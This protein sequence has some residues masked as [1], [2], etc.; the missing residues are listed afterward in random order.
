MNGI[1][2]DKMKQEEVTYLV[3]GVPRPGVL[4]PVFCAFDLSLQL[5]L[6]AAHPLQAGDKEMRIELLDNV[7]KGTFHQLQTPSSSALRR[8]VALATS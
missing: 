4:S 8:F 7:R 3:V 5:F 2:L 1:R 6:S